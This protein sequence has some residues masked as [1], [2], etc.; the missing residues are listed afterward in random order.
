MKSTLKLSLAAAAGSAIAFVLFVSVPV[1]P[2]LRDPANARFAQDESRA[3][4]NGRFAQANP[5]ARDPANARFVQV[6]SRDPHN[7][8]FAQG[9]GL[10]GDP[11]KRDQHH[12]RLASSMRSFG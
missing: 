9:S 10:Y 6:Y 1:N 11:D 5:D 2:D 12:Q 7:S 8:R 3:P 4:D